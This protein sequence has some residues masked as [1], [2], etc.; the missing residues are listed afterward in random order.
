MSQEEHFMLEEKPRSVITSA[1]EA[2]TAPNLNSYLQTAGDLQASQTC[3]GEGTVLPSTTLHSSNENI[4]SNSNN[5]S[6]SAAG[7]S[8]KLESQTVL[9][10]PPPT[11]ESCDRAEPLRPVFTDDRMAGSS[12]SMLPTPY[13]HQQQQ[14]QP[15]YHQQS[16]SNMPHTVE[17]TTVMFPT[18]ASSTPIDHSDS[19]KLTMPASA[20]SSTLSMDQQQNQA[21]YMDSQKQQQQQQH[22]HPVHTP[23]LSVPAQHISPHP[24]QFRAP[25]L[26][27]GYSQLASSVPRFFNDTEQLLDV[28]NRDQT[29]RYT[30]TI[31]SKIDRGFFLA[32]NVW[33][34][35]RRN[36]FQVSS[37]FLLMNSSGP[38][39]SPDCPCV[40]I[41]NGVPRT[42]SQFL[43]GISALVVNSERKVDLIQQTAKRDKGPQMIPMPQPVRSGGSIHGRGVGINNNVATFER[44]QFKNATANNGKRRAAQQYYALQMTLFAE[45]DDGQ[46]IPVAHHISANLVVRG[47]SPN[48]YADHSSKTDQKRYIDYGTTGGVGYDRFSPYGATSISSHGHDSQQR[49]QIALPYAQH[50]GAQHQPPPPL[51]SPGLVSQSSS[52]LTTPMNPTNSNQ[53]SGMGSAV[54]QGTASSSVN[55]S[56]DSGFDQQATSQQY[57]HQAHQYSGY[58]QQQQHHGAQGNISVSANQT[59]NIGITANNAGHVINPAQPSPAPPGYHFVND[60]AAAAAGA[61]SA[62]STPIN[63]MPITRHSSS[64]SMSNPIAHQ[65]QHQPPPNAAAYR[66]QI[67]SG[68]MGLMP[69][70]GMTPTP[71]SSHIS[72]TA[73]STPTSA[74][75]WAQNRAASAFTTTASPGLV[76]QGYMNPPRTRDPNAIASWN[77]R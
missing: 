5:I 43:I 75:A 21:H 12:Y 58:P 46:Q 11:Q 9:P 10:P 16:M 63:A 44:I 36:Y 53:G 50:P 49:S 3:A 17:S 41:D 47:R 48:H 64:A 74:D 59:F 4:I 60:Y 15:G 6:S 67:A 45:C 57:H 8:I 28:L 72:P 69:S 20:V 39:A 26:A 55:W 76:Q 51:M 68:D 73:N 32:D 22:H 27:P 31:N 35:Y 33:A 23:L 18:Q 62:F 61:P 38:I 29:E 2:T 66:S 40:V 70:V 54:D 42:V 56:R 37:A 52:T 77:G 13:H 14:H 24:T 34:C 7:T 19:S 30:V 71:P 25:E 1:P 65:I